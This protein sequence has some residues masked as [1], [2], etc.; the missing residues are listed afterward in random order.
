MDKVSEAPTI[1]F[2]LFFEE[3]K[4][5]E[6]IPDKI[7]FKEAEK[8]AMEAWIWENIFK[9]ESVGVPGAWL[10][11]H[12]EKTSKVL[13]AAGIN[14]HD[15]N[16][17]KTVM[18]SACL[19][20]LSTQGMYL[21]KRYDIST[22][23]G[24][25]ALFTKLA[26]IATA[27]LFHDIGYLD[28]IEDQD[29]FKKEDLDNHAKVGS[30]NIFDFGEK[31]IYPATKTNKTKK[32]KYAQ[33]LVETLF[34]P[35]VAER[36]LKMEGK[37]FYKSLRKIRASISS[38]DSPESQDG[39]DETSK[40]DNMSA[41]AI[42]VYLADKTHIGNRLYSGANPES[43]ETINN[44]DI[45]VIHDR[46]THLIKNESF[47]IRYEPGPTV[48]EIK[49]T[50]EIPQA[51]KDKGFCSENFISDFKNGFGKRYKHAQ[52]T[53]KRLMHRE[54]IPHKDTEFKVIANIDGTTVEIDLPKPKPVDLSLS[55]SMR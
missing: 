40:I 17:V 51:Y 37:K 44:S 1:N 49:L 33:T 16:H 4:N 5:Q 47:G 2:P 11:D 21:K 24:S 34:Q 41:E 45:S 3:L 35:A 19:I 27:A 32:N 18:V 46:I 42:C 38:H 29:N 30:E 43:D 10:H 28:C 52:K 23:E 31:R 6:E 55:R 9:Q 7:E 8:E 12:M 50:V 48:F 26:T 22:P 39:T 36:L 14:K 54:H 20:F 53:F 13:E 25:E 15:F